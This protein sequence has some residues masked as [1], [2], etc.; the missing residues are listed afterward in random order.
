VFPQS[1]ILA[2]RSFLALLAIATHPALAQDFP[3]LKPGLWEMDRAL[4]RPPGSANAPAPPSTSRT[5][6]C[7]D[8]SVERDMFNMAMGEMSGRCSK[9]DFKLTGNRMTGDLVCDLGGTTMHSKSLMV[10][11]GDRAYRAEVDTTYDPPFMG[12]SQS[13]TVLTARNIGPCKPGQRPGDFVMP[14][15]RTMNIRDI[16]NGARGAQGSVRPKTSQ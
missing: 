10:L 14:D 7:L 4:D 16:M 2:P 11:D 6:M 1:S 3:K 15:G 13:R 9:H 8:E 5:T 12:R